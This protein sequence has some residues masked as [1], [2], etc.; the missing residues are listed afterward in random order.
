MRINKSQGSLVFGIKRQIMIGEGSS[1]VP[2]SIVALMGSGQQ[3]CHYEVSRANPFENDPRERREE[4][5]CLQAN[6]I[7]PRGGEPFDEAWKK[8]KYTLLEFPGEV[9]NESHSCVP[10]S[11]WLTS[12]LGYWFHH[13]Y[14]TSF[15]IC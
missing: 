10:I 8:E 13:T 4:K 3:R 9:L 6:L 15:I 5:C 12:K 14:N 2:L 7:I 1:D 11:L